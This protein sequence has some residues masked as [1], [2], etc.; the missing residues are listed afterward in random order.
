MVIVFVGHLLFG[1]KD[2]QGPPRNFREFVAGTRCWNHMLA[3]VVDRFRFSQRIGSSEDKSEVFDIYMDGW[4]MTGRRFRIDYQDVRRKQLPEKHEIR[5]LLNSGV[6][7]SSLKHKPPH[8]PQFVYPR[9]SLDAP[10]VLLDL[11]NRKG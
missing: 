6:L 8:M 1:T 9:W 4:E 5:Y 10:W 7:A 2:F 11:F 3:P